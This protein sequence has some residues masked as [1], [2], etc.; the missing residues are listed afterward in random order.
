MRYTSAL[1]LANP[2]LS[3]LIMPQLS[4]LSRSIGRR[5]L[6]AFTLVEILVAIAIVV[7]VVLV[8]AQII[9]SAQAIW[10]HSEARTDA[11]REA[12]AALHLMAR[13]LA[14]ALT[15]DRAP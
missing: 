14:L 11:F 2:A 1:P 9:S 4:L 10:R 7:F 5:R 15:D 6:A 13:D 12:R 8:L 3:H